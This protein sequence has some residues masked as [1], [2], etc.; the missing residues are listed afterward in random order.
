[1]M[2]KLLNFS[3]ATNFNWTREKKTIRFDM[4]LATDGTTQTVLTYPHLLKHVLV[5]FV[6]NKQ[7]FFSFIL[8]NDC[9]IRNPYASF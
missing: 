5:I 4:L 7:I 2:M 3:S 1:M 9:L 8:I 6:E